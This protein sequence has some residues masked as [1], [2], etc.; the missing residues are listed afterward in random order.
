[1]TGPYHPGLNPGGEGDTVSDGVNFCDW[2]QQPVTAVAEAPG[3]RVE[4]LPTGTFARGMLELG[5]SAG[6]VLLD[7]TGRRVADLAPGLNDIRHLAPGVYFI[8]SLLDSR[9]S[10][11]VSKVVVTR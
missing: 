1:L 8:H 2:L 10:S 9:H 3:P 6:A 11:L 4:R 5:G 7:I